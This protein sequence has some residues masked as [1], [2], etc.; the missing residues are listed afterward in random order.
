MVSLPAAFSDRPPLLPF[1]YSLSASL[2][3]RYLRDVHPFTRACPERSRR[4]H[5]SGSSLD[6]SHLEAGRLSLLPLGVGF[7]PS[8]YQERTPR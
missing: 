6:R 2:A 3:G 7:A 5:P 4:V 8:R 1:G